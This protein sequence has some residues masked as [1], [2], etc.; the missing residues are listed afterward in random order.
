MEFSQKENFKI[1]SNAPLNVIQYSLQMLSVRYNQENHI[2]L[3]LSS[4]DNRDDIDKIYK[5]Y[6]NDWYWGMFDFF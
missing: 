3:M 4:E 5:L 6:Q 2:M 1:F